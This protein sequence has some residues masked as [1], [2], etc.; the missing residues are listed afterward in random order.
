MIDT[1]VFYFNYV[2]DLY[3]GNEGHW[4]FDSFWVK[5]SGSYTRAGSPAIAVPAEQA[6]DMIVWD[7]E[8]YV[9]GPWQ[10]YTKAYH[11]YYQREFKSAW[12]VA[13]DPGNAK[14]FVGQLAKV[15][16]AIHRQYGSAYTLSAPS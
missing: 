9:N 15:V 1:N 14:G 3:V 5:L 13:F 4:K 2:N 8:S 10:N 7:Q 16:N 6:Q 11:A 12:A